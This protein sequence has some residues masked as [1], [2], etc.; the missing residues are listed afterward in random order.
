MIRQ[1]WTYIRENMNTSNPVAY[2]INRK[3]RTVFY[4]ECTRE[5][6]ITT[7]V[8]SGIEP[9]FISYSDARKLNTAA[10]EAQ[11]DA[12]EVLFSALIHACEKF[13][14]DYKEQVKTLLEQ[15]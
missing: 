12:G 10:E 5:G 15:F 9:H 8:I 7:N 14:E 3:E 11:K 1:G 13:E 6:Y 2:Y 4:V